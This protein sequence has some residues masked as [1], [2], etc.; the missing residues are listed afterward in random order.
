MARCRDGPLQLVK[1]IFGP[2]G[3]DPSQD[4]SGV[5]DSGKQSNQTQNHHQL[6]EHVMKTG[7]SPYASG[8]GRTLVGA[9]ALAVVAAFASPAMAYTPAKGAKIL[10]VVQVDYQG[11]GGVGSYQANASTLVTVNLVP[12]A[13]TFSG[14]PTSVSPGDTNGS[15]CPPTVNSGVTTTALNAISANANGDDD[16]DLSLSGITPTNATNESVTYRILGSDGSELV[17]ATSGTTTLSAFGSS[18]LVGVKGGTADTLLFDGGV[19]LTAMFSVGDI[20]VVKDATLGNIDYKVKA[21][22]NGTAVSHDNA[23]ATPH[24]TLG[25]LHAETYGELQLEAFS[26]TIGGT[27][28]GSNTTPAFDTDVPAA[29]DVVGEMVLVEVSVSADANSQS[30][31]GTVAFSFDTTDSNSDTTADGCTVT[32]NKA[33]KL[34]IEKQVQNITAGGS[35]GATATGVT[36]DVLEYTVTVNNPASS[37]ANTVVVTD[38]VPVYTTLVTS[39]GNFATATMGATTV[40]ITTVNTDTEDGTVASGDAAGTAAG[41]AMT[42]QLGNGNVGISGSETGGTLAGSDTVVIKY[43]VTID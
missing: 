25:S 27:A 42:F 36:G 13:L 38:A 39:S 3:P 34:T 1:K 20:V 29:G 31:D 17:A 6:K 26:V 41:S 21:V 22:T 43:R 10:N 19:N 37:D 16:Y 12:A 32:F 28:Y 15:N 7:K 30:N 5:R 18:L 2:I 9:L 4:A 11:T 14:P 40:D 24:D 8:L 23:G 35:I 33:A